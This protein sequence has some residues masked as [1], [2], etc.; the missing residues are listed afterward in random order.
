MC[1]DEMFFRIFLRSAIGNKLGDHCQFIT[2]WIHEDSF[3]DLGEEFSIFRA[4]GVATLL[5]TLSLL[6]L[7]STKNAYN[8][9]ILCIYIQIIKSDD[10]ESDTNIIN[11]N[12]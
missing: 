2:K 11:K 10:N 6:E 12:K 5:F 3:T 7:Y 4:Q 9:I 8:I 1:P